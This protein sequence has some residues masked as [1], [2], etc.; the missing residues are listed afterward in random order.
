MI[1]ERLLEAAGK[2]ALPL[3]ALVRAHLRTRAVAAQYVLAEGEGCFHGMLAR[4]GN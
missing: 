1:N 4:Q 2:L 3:A